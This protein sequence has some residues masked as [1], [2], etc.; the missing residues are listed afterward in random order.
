MIP[1]AHENYY[2]E[3]MSGDPERVARIFAEANAGSVDAMYAL[4]VLYCEGRGV[5]VDYE[6]SLE[7]L[8]RARDLGDPDAERMIRVVAQQ[9]FLKEC[10][11]RM[12]GGG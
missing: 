1:M 5:P 4:G 11:E 10:E 7:W 2:L 9:L 12:K 8:T 6:R 3:L